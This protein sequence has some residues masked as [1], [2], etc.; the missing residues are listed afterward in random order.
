MASVE[1]DFEEGIWPFGG[2][3]DFDEVLLPKGAACLKISEMLASADQ[4]AGEYSFGG[5]VDTLPV[6]PGLFVEE[7]GA[8]SVPLTSEQAEKV[9]VKCEKSPFGHNLDTKM[10]ENVR[11]SWQLAPD[12]VKINNTQW[13]SGMDKLVT[14]IAQRLGY[15]NV[16]LQCSLYKLLVYGE[17]GHFLKHQ[18]TE[19]ED[20]MIATLVIQPPSTHEGGDLVVYRGGKARYRHDFGKADGSA[21]YLPHYA[22]HY[23]DAE[24]S[25]EKVTKGHRFALVYSIC[26]PATMRHLKRNPNSPMADDLAD[27]ISNMAAG[28]ESFALLLFHE[29]TKKSIQG[30][31]AGALKGVDSARFRTLVEANAVVPADKKLKFFIAKLS[32]KIISC[33]PSAISC[34]W[35]EEDRKQAIHWYS[36][37]GKD[38]GRSRDAKLRDKLNF[39]NPGQETFT[40]LWEPHQSSHEEAYTGNEG[41]TKTTTYSTYAI[42]AW[43][44]A[45]HAQKA[46]EV[47]SVEHAVEALLEQKP[48]NAAALR[49]CLNIA[50]TKLGSGKKSWRGDDKASVR[51]CRSFCELLVDAGDS[52]LAKLFFSNYCPRL[53]EL[54]ENT[55]LIP[56]II[57]IT[58]TF[59]WNDIGEELLDVLCNE[60]HEYDDEG[61]C[62]ETDVEMTLQVV[63]G[64]DDGAAQQALLK[65]AVERAIASD[66]KEFETNAGHEDLSSS[67][68]F[69]ILWKHAIRSDDKQPFEAVVNHFD[70]KDPSELGPAT[71][72]FSPYFDDLE[73]TDEKVAALV[74][75]AAKRVKWLEDEIHELDTP[76]S[77]KMPNATFPDNSRLEGFLRGGKTSMNTKGLLTFKGLPEARKYATTCVREHQDGASFRMAAAGRGKEAFVT[78]TKTRKWFDDNQKAI[79]QYKDELMNLKTRYEGATGERSPK[80]PRST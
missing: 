39:L 55:T 35:R 27:E 68:V 65:K 71:E 47:M 13:E 49:T 12:Q 11:K 19:K 30:L 53:G 29:Y 59:D 31:G 48:V 54:Y 38:L 26:L 45:H 40:Q 67:K 9:I 56:G 41:P 37:T 78:I 43:P 52:A 46:A 18:D 8:I 72:A 7:V 69:G 70:Q 16:P 42:V 15:E 4:K 44:A 74:V 62:G 58:R 14:T 50:S 77:W 60:T 80:K 76:F 34:D 1:E 25:L 66:S 36:T 6:A 5:V 61:N 2:E 33:P 63:D 28:D 3:G 73:E 21:P 20:G 75:L 79:V 17:G 24:H 51:F 23:A 57:E 64:L 32:H 10:D 22:V